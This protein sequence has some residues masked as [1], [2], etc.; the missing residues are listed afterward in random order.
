[1]WYYLPNK[2]NEERLETKDTIIVKLE[3]E[4]VVTLTANGHAR[5]ISTGFLACFYVNDNPVGMWREDIGVLIYNSYFYYSE[6]TGTTEYTTG[7][8]WTP[9]N[10]SQEIVL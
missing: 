9:M 7:T 5:A 8:T 1:M 4:S 2:G 3:R 10:F 6:S